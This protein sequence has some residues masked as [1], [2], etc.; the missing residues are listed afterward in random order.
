[1]ILNDRE[2][3]TG[4]WIV[5]VLLWVLS[6]AETKTSLQAFLRVLLS[7]QILLGFL[8]IVAYVWGETLILSKIGLWNGSH[9][10]K[11]LIW[12]FTVAAVSFVNVGQATNQV[13]FIKEVALRNLKMSV[14]L[15]FLVNFYTFPFLVEFFLVPFLVFIAG[16]QVVAD[17]KDEYRPVK[18]IVDNILAIF[19][20]SLLMYA[21]YAIWADFGRF[22]QL[23]TLKKFA[24]PIELSLLFIPLIYF[25]AVLFLYEPLFIRLKH[26]VK[27]EAIYNFV[28]WRVLSKCNLSL[29][30]LRTWSERLPGIEFASTKAVL[31]SFDF[32]RLDERAPPPDGFRGRAWGS[33]PG[34]EMTKFSGPTDDDLTTYTF[35]KG[36][37][38]PPLFG[39]PVASECYQFERGKLYGVSVFLDGSDAFDKMR[40]ELQRLYGPATFANIPAELYKWKWEDRGIQI[41]LYFQASHQRAT[42]DATCS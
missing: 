6:K 14:I 12:I 15:S 32:R 19:G 24:V 18:K 21:I 5:I 38:S 22:A 34:P 37:S 13:Q 30:R 31:A 33:A 42:V 10:S 36:C 27:D 40:Y 23:D 1:M 16:L 3:A 20:L 25:F 9:V 41:Q 2:L 11:T 26:F 17:R 7:R 35:A 29:T 4:T 8:L 39:V 28:K